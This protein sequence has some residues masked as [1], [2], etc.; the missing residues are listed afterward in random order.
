MEHTLTA[1]CG[2][3]GGYDHAGVRNGDPD[4]GYDLCE[5]VIGNTVIKHVR[6]DIIG[7]SDSRHTDRMRADAGLGFEMFRMHDDTGEI[8]AVI[9]K[10]K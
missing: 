2:F 5:H 3:S 9:V 6:I 10:S 1:L 4:T 8:I 7:A